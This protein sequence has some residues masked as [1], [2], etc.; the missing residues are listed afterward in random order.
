MPRLFT[1][2]ETFRVDFPDKAILIYDSL[3][4]LGSPFL[5]PNVMWFHFGLSLFLME[6]EI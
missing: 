6:T 5:F 4:L 1:V 3:C 2:F